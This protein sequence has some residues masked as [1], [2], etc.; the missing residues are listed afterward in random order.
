MFQNR[1]K[2]FIADLP[3]EAIRLST[4]QVNDH[5]VRRIDHFGD[6]SY[7][8]GV[9]GT[10]DAWF[11]LIE[12]Y[13]S[14]VPYM[15]TIGNHEFDYSEGNGENDPSGEERFSPSWWNGGSDSGGECR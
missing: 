12:P 4:A 6:I 5:G 8:C 1:E 14:Q 15:I 2:W 11:D 7:A 3:T 9:S 13:A 10:W